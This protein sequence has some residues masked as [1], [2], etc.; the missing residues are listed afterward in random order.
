MVL[1]MI[2]CPATGQNVS[3]GIRSGTGMQSFMRIP[4]ALLAGSI[5]NALAGMSRS[6]MNPLPL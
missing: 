6:A 4:N 5:M 1:F 3:T 2:V